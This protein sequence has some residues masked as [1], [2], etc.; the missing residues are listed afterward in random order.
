MNKKIQTYSLLSSCSN[1]M[2]LITGARCAASQSSTYYY[3][4]YTQWGSHA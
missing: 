1:A 3:A 4:Y 2:V